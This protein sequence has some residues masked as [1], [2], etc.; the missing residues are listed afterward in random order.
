MRLNGT[1]EIV[2]F[3]FHIQQKS[4]RL[5]G[6]SQQSVSAFSPLHWQKCSMGCSSQFQQY[7]TSIFCADFLWPK[8]LQTQTISSEMLR[9]TVLYQK[10]ARKM[11]VKLTI[12]R[13]FRNVLLIQ[14]LSLSLLSHYSSSSDCISNLHCKQHLENFTFV[15]VV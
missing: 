1:L 4:T 15:H 3:S 11:L 14:S 7:F 13:V 8:K 10:A 12:E 9:I 6:L 2:Y 5:S